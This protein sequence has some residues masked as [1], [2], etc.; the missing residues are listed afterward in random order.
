MSQNKRLVQLMKKLT[1]D[2]IKL[3]IPRASL[4]TMLMGIAVPI[5]VAEGV[6]IETMQ[7][8]LFAAYISYCD[9]AAQDKQRAH[10]SVVDPE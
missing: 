1:E 8:Y 5:Y 6:A 2:V 3:G 4:G 10:L 9:L 7:E